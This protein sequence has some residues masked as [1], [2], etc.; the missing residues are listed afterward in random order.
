M[1]ITRLYV[2]YIVSC[3]YGYIILSKQTILIFYQLE[4]AGDWRRGGLEPRHKG[5]IAVLCA[6]KASTN[7]RSGGA[8]IN[9]YIHNLINAIDIEI[10]VSRGVKLYT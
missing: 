7:R 5:G 9:K 3:V 10:E 8:H 1:L 2:D 4:R 6:L